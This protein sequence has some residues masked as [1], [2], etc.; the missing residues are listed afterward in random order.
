MRMMR[1]KASALIFVFPLV[2]GA[3][4]GVFY[5]MDSKK[6]S[7][8]VGKA[9]AKGALPGAKEG[10]R[11]PASTHDEEAADPVVT[12]EAK[13]Q[14]E[15]RLKAIEKSLVAFGQDGHGK[16]CG[17][18]EYFGAG[19]KHPAPTAAD[20]DALKKSYWGIKADLE[21]FLVK[22]QLEIPQETWKQM[23]SSLKDLTIHKPSIEL[24]A[25]LAWRGIPVLTRDG[26]GKPM[27]RLG[28]GFM[29]LFREK[30]QRAKFELARVMAQVWSPCEL[31]SHHADPV[32]TGLLKCMKLEGAEGCGQGQYSE[33]GWAVSTAVAQQVAAPGCTIPAFADASGKELKACADEIPF[34]PANHGGQRQPASDQNNDA[35]HESENNSDVKN[36]DVKNHNSASHSQGG[37]H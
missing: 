24:E 18:F 32:W 4:V 17:S 15:V 26:E 3:S 16:T 5:W 23:R 12:A 9:G 20:W 19:L 35:D 14:A 8:A 27:V 31:S 25:D 37:G 10:E 28:A 6:G 29:K 33:A 30:P 7:I 34:V 2:V 21:K 11:T 1:G 13:K 36:H 22:H